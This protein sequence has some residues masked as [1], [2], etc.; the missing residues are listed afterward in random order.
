MTAV[1]AVTPVVTPDV[2]PI[3]ATAVL[4]LLQVPPPLLVRVVVNPTHMVVVPL[5]D[6]GLGFTL[7]TAVE[8]TLPQ[9]NVTK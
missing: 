9:G 1:P 5:I 4:L 3:V 6:P 2:L 7:N 8:Y